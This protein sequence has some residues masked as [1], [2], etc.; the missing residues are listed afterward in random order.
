[1]LHLS[2]F[3]TMRSDRTHSGILSSDTTHASGSVIT[4]IRQGLSFSQL[5]TSSLSSLNPYSHY[6]EINISLNIF[7]S[8]P[9]LNVNAPPIRSSSTNGRTNSFS[10]SILPSSKNLFILGDINCHHPSGTQESLPTPAGR[11]YLTGP[12]LLTSSP[13]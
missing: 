5:S 9:F 13:Q 3:S 7:S 8:M 1:M 2:G 4:F 12:S 6:V 10:P 11:K